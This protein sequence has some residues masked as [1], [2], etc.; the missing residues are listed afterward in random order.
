MKNFFNYEN[1]Q[2]Q[3]TILENCLVSF[4]KVFLLGNKSLTT[5]KEC[6]VFVEQECFEETLK[7]KLQVLFYY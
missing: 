6:R 4:M 3:F 1:T 7:V 5:S 2:T